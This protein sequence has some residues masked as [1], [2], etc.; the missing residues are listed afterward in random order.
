M[1]WLSV[2]VC[3]SEVDVLSMHVCDWHVSCSHAHRSIG[4]YH[5]RASNQIHH[6]RSYNRRKENM[7]RAQDNNV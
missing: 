7:N 4:F 3:F 2:L 6:V 5:Q 1:I